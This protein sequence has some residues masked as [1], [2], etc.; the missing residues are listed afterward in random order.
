[1]IADPA[2]P[3]KTSL[4]ENEVLIALL[5]PGSKTMTDDTITKL[6]LLNADA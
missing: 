5:T 4:T 3:M 6:T 2:N 1:M